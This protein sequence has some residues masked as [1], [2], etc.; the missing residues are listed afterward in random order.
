MLKETPVEVKL[1]DFL[2]KHIDEII[3]LS[4]VEIQATGLAHE[5][6]K[7]QLELTHF[8]DLYDTL[9]YSRLIARA[10]SENPKLEQIVDLGAG[11]SVPTLCAL[12]QAKRDDISVLAVDIDPN[13]ISV[14]WKNAKKMGLEK[15][16]TFFQTSME[17]MNLPEAVLGKNSLIVSNPPYIPAPKYLDDYQYLPID[18]GRDGAKY[19]VNIL[20]QNYSKDTELA[21]FWGSL[22]NPAMIISLIEE[23]YDVLHVDATRV[24]F[25]EYTTQPEIKKYLYKLKEEGVV[26][27]EEDETQIVIGT[28]LRPKISIA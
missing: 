26:F 24:H 2:D 13:A 14:S 17:L 4:H 16:Y 8:N 9:L 11:S 22:S 27:F 10:I 18:G 12:K 1:Y 15:S 6:N 21:L 20:N 7:C 19:L 28:I 25:G 3:N 5:F 23:K